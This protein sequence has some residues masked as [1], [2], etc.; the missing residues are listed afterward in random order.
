MIHFCFEIRHDNHIIVTPRYEDRNKEPYM[1]NKFLVNVTWMNEFNI[2]E[3]D[4][5]ITNNGLEFGLYFQ[6]LCNE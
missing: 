6:Y 2:Y 4:S 5:R 3:P 1:Q